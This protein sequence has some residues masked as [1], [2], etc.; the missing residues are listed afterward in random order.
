MILWNWKWSESESCSVVSDSLWSRD[1]TVQGI[2]QARILEWVAFPFSRGSSQPRD[3]TQ[4]S[5]IAGGFFTSWATREDCTNMPEKLE[6]S[7]AATAW[8]RSVFIPIPKSVLVTQ[9][10]LTLCYPM[11]CNPPGS[12][13]HGIFQAR[14]LEWVAISFK[15]VQT[16]TQLHLSHTLA[17]SCSIFPRIRV[18]SNESVLHIRWPKYWSFI[19][20]ISPSN[21]YSWLISF[22]IHWFLRWRRN[23]TGRPLSPKKI[24]QKII[25][26]LSKCHRT[27]SERWRRTPGTRKASHCLRK[28]VGQII[29]DKK[30]DKR[31][32]DGDPSRRGSCKRGE[33]SEN[34]KTLSPAGLWGVLESQRATKPG[35]KNK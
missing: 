29:K 25:W 18:F 17:K 12:S 3:Q 8:K 20:S 30:K 33:V 13:V 9:L 28:E 5:H 26:I 2:L 22:R 27:T 14:I 11:D 23:R 24:Q 7:A 21:E 35:G 34:Q 1:Y 6:N 15:N 31:V 4:V 32:R 19:G 16:T 10:C